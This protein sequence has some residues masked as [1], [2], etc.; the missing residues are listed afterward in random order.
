MNP[1]DLR[2]ILKSIRNGKQYSDFL[3]AT[4]HTHEAGEYP[5][6]SYPTDFLVELAH[7]AI[8]NGADAFVGHGVH[9]LRGVEIYKGRPFFTA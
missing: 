5:S 8:D 1:D 4:I 3:I 9:V 7:K 2:D 6:D